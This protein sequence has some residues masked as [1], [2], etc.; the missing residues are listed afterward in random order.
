MTISLKAMDESAFIDYKK[1]A[2]PAYAKDNVTAGRWPESD[3]LARAEKEFERL[4]PDGVNSQDN[5]L[6]TIIANELNQNVG[7]IWVKIEHNLSVKSAFIYDIEIAEAHRQQGY[8]KA[9]LSRI[10]KAV[11]EL[12]ATS[13]GLH[14]FNNNAAAMALYERLGFNMVSHNMNKMLHTK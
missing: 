14:V 1:H 13:L 9:G 7:Y 11:T 12:G 4:L 5:Y 10:E 8:A 2:I 6:F 3:A